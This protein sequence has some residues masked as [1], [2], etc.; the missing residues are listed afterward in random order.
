[1]GWVPFQWW[2]GGGRL[3]EADPPLKWDKIPISL[4]GGRRKAGG[5]GPTAEMGQNSHLGGGWGAEGVRGWE[6][7]LVVVVLVDWWWLVEEWGWWRAGGGDW[8]AGDG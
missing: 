5:G 6:G 1:M 7:G 4:V 2:V 3:A 8:W